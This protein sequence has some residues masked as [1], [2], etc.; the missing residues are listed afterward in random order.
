MGLVWEG[1]GRGGRTPS[2][3]H[4]K[5]VKTCFI[6]TPSLSSSSNEIF[7]KKEKF[8]SCHPPPHSLKS[9]CF[10]LSFNFDFNW[11]T[12]QWKFSSCIYITLERGQGLGTGVCLMYI[13]CFVNYIINTRLNDLS[14]STAKTSHQIYGGLGFC[15]PEHNSAIWKWHFP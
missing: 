5:P 1:G 3:K 4:E 6:V 9:T 11:M 14:V 15:N 12:K 7:I 10:M 13:I 2:R 8:F